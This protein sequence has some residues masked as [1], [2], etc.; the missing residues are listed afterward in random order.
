MSTVSSQQTASF[1]LQTF[2]CLAVIRMGKRLKRL[3]FVADFVFT[4]M[5]ILA[6]SAMHG[7]R[8]IRCQ[9]DLESVLCSAL[10]CIEKLT[11]PT[12]MGTCDKNI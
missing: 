5:Y 10:R 9:N 2:T 4:K 3:S 7:I 12:I 1:V 8:G 11:L 6:Y